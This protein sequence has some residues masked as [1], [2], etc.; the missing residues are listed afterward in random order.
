M[1]DV[2]PPH[3]AADSWKDY[4]KLRPTAYALDPEGMQAAHERLEQALK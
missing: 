3:Q 1:L 4:S 2:H